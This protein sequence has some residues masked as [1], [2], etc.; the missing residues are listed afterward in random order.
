M[1]DP[2][3]SAMWITLAVTAGGIVGAILQAMV[4]RGEVRRAQREGAR[5][6]RELDATRARLDEISDVCRRSLE[7]VGR[8]LEES[9]RGANRAI[10]GRVD[11][12]LGVV[13]A[14]E[15]AEGMLEAPT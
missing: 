1:M 14:L 3:M 13:R 11:A 2:L 7:L 6:A 10:S 8:G 9:A 15:E 12:R 4:G 5:V